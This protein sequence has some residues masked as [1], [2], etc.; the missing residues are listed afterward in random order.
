MRPSLNQRSDMDKL[1]TEI[2]SSNVRTGLLIAGSGAIT[3]GAIMQMRDANRTG[4]DDRL[5]QALSAAGAGLQQAGNAQ[6]SQGLILGLEAAE[7]ALSLL[8]AD[9]KAQADG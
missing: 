2:R 3:A 7:V 4:L 9:L 6:G 1:T 5:G 8:I